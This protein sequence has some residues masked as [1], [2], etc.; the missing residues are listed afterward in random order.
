[1]S[2]IPTKYLAEETSQLGYRLQP[3]HCLRLVK[4]VFPF[5]HI[6]T[7]TRYLGKKIPVYVVESSSSRMLVYLRREFLFQY[8]AKTKITLL[9]NE[10]KIRISI[11]EREIINKL[12]IFLITRKKLN[13]NPRML[14]IRFVMKEKKTMNLFLP[15]KSLDEFQFARPSGGKNTK[16]NHFESSNLT[17]IFY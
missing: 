7:Q 15:T 17:L 12:S 16:D 4:S 14:A 11:V 5:D 10:I 13:V 3:L 9:W 2:F 6:H 1:M 8:V